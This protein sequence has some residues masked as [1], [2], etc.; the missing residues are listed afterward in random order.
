MI[1][2]G[3]VGRVPIKKKLDVFPVFKQYKA[4]VELESEKKIKCLR[5]YNDGEY[6]DD[7]FLTF[8]K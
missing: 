5:T 2:P 7:E 3:D 6:T 8:C 4:W 1:I